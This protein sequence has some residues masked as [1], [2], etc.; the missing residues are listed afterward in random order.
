MNAS[1]IGQN[2]F[3]IQSYDK[4]RNQF[5]AGAELTAIIHKHLFVSLLYQ[6]EVGENQHSHTAGIKGSWRF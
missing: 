1:F 2:G 5:A 6:G 3:T 4:V